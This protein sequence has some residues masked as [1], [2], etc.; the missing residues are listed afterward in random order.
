MNKRKAFTLIELLVVIAIIALLMAI[1][2]PTLNRAKKQARSAACQM[3]LHQWGNIWSMYCDD[4]DGYFCVESPT[5]EWPRGNWIVALR[6]LY[7]TRAG[8][9]MCPMARKRRPDGLQWGST[10]NT[11]IMGSGGVGDRR[12][13]GSY[14]VNCWIYKPRPRQMSIQS[15]PTKYNWKTKDVAG[16]NKIPVFADSM[17]RGGGPYE[18]GT[19]GNPP[20]FDGQW[21]GYDMEMMHFVIDRHNGS[22]NSTFMDWSVRKVGLKEF[23]TLKWHRQ[24][25]TAGL[26]T[27]AGG[28]GPSDWPEWMRHF[29]DY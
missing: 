24:F 17:W 8:I 9:L 29:K 27:T 20:G 18:K 23:W 12:E 4:N 3:N 25:N 15:R 1:L 21:L 28:C 11:Y 16:G 5:V 14:G 22:I 10:F 13:E 6:P 2:M 7:R 19:R 26:W